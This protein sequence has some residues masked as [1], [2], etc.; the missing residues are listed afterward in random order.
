MVLLIAAPEK[1]WIMI[2]SELVQF[3][4]NTNPD[5]TYREVDTIV[6]VFFEEIVQRL[7]A[8]GR[9]ELRGFGSFTARARADRTGRNPRTGSEVAVDAKRVPHFKA[10]K[11]IRAR[12][13]P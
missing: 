9:V 10:G 13:N 3:I 7:E 1:G 2:R 11:E 5:L 4:A 8:D 12:L 6:D